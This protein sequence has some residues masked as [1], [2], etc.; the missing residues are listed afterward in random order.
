[1]T[2]I[3]KL[4]AA[5]TGNNSLVCVGL[6]PALEKLPVCLGGCE[7]P[8]FEFNKAIID[9]TCD[10]VC[11]YKP[12][13]AYYAGQDAED[14]L[15]MTMEYLRERCPNIPVILDAK[16]GD[17]GATAQ[18][19]AREAFERYK[20]DA[21]TVNPYM[22]TDTLKPFTDYADRGTVILCRTSNPNSGDIQDLKHDELE[23]YKHVAKLAEKVWNYNKNIMLVIGATYPVELKAVR[24]ICPDIPFLV[25]GV[26]AQGGDAAAVVKN[27]ADSR[28]LGLVVNSSRGIIYADSSENF[29]AGAADATRQL[30]DTLNQYR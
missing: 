4:E 19:Y 30:R 13:I 26:G 16:R 28:G 10:L 27:G 8:I 15:T 3:E 14:E 11:C 17:I 9:A 18:M 5:W 7:Y 29:A 6:D 20:A 24:E 12:Q 1:M 23:V 22:G 25:P 2:F 21:V